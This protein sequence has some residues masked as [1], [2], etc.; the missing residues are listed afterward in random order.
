MCVCVVSE[1]VCVCVL[2]AGGVT[3]MRNDLRHR[4]PAATA[5]KAKNI[6]NIIT[7]RK[8]AAGTADANTSSNR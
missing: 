5:N 2:G 4:Q 8:K 6:N 7:I 3:H 1:C